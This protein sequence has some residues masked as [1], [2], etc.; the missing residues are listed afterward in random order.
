MFESTSTRVYIDLDARKPDFYIS[1]D[2]FLV[3]GSMTFRLNLFR[4]KDISS[5]RHFIQYD[6]LSKFRRKVSKFV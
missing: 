2:R 3:M 5:K 1:E 4:L 6:I